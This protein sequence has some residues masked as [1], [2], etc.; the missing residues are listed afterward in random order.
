MAEAPVSWVV[1]ARLTQAR[2]Q[3]A[4]RPARWAVFAVFDRLKQTMFAVIKL[5]GKQYTVQKGEYLTVDRLAETEGSTFSPPVLFAQDGEKT[6]GDP[7]ASVAVTAHVDEHLL[8]PKIRVFTYNPK[9]SSKKMRGH[10]SRLTKIT[11]QDIA[12]SKGKK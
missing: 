10:R 2:I 6:I 7:S 3:S 11:I 12:V 9:K 4:E 5:G 1:R 8:G